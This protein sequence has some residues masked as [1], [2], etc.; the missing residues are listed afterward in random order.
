MECALGNKIYVTAHS[1]PSYPLKYFHS[2]KPTVLDLPV[3]SEAV[4]VFLGASQLNRI[5]LRFI[6][7]AL[8]ILETIW[9]GYKIKQLGVDFYM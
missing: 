5:S 8:T 2:V 9:T 1:D 6:F 4:V 3:L 7:F